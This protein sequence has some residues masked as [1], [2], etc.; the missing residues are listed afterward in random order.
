M[1][2]LEVRRHSLTKKGPGRGMGT[3]L[4]MAGVAFARRVGAGSGPFD[5]VVTSTV[6]R[7]TE[8]AVAMGFA[9]DETVEMA[10]VVLPDRVEH[11]AQWGWAHPFAVYAR[12]LVDVPEFAARVEVQRALWTAAVESVPEGG[13]ALVVAHGGM[14]EPTAVAC[15]PA[16]DHRSWGPP[17]AH[18][19]G[20]RLTYTDGRFT[21]I[22]FARPTPDDPAPEVAASRDEEL[23]SSHDE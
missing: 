14:I 9:V 6:P 20:V 21:G 22:R 10:S 18:C 23:L 2:W 4:S 8:T 19:H 17:M 5:R 11:H 13:A 7:T 3:Q 16:A 12:L 1:R 15:L